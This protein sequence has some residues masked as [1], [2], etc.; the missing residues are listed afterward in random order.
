MEVTGKLDDPSR[1]EQV[2]K[3]DSRPILNLI[4]I[5][6]GHFFFGSTGV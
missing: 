2:P 1:E 5:C 4:N 6:N 3:I